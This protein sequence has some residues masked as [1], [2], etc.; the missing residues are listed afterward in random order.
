MFCIIGPLCG[1]STSLLVDSLH[2]GPVIQNFNDFF[3][4]SLDKLLNKHL[5]GQWNKTPRHSNDYAIQAL[6][7]KYTS[8]NTVIIG[9]ENGLSPV[10]GQ[11]LI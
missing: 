10:Q 5:S 1:E 11:A 4:V 6:W 8:V 3:V 2:K 9:S 7:C